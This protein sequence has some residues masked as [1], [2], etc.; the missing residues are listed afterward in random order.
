MK[1]NTKHYC[2]KEPYWKVKGFGLSKGNM[3]LKKT[4]VSV[5]LKNKDGVLAYPNSFVIKT[6]DALEHESETQRGTELFLIPF[7]SCKEIARTK[8]ALRCK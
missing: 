7:S 6:K 8:G 5:R 3:G 1:P 2:I 4:I